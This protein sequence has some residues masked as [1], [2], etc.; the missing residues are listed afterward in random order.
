MNPLSLTSKLPQV[1]TTI[2]TV[3]SSLAREH[4]AINLSQGFPDIPCDDDL[5]RRVNFY[6]QKGLNQYAPMQGAMP[7]REQISSLVNELYGANYDPT[8]E[9][10]VT[11]GATE[12]LF[13]AIT[14]LIHEGDEVLIIEPAYDA[15]IPII[16]LSG[17]VPVSISL[18]FPDYKIDWEHVKKLINGRTRAIMLNSPHNPTGSVLSAD[19]LQ[20]LQKIIHSNNIFIISDEVWEHTVYDGE[21]HQSVARYPELASRSLVIS[22]FG[23]ALNATG[24]KVGYCLAPAA[25]TKEFRKVHQFVTFSTATPLQH[26]IADYLQYHR[27]RVTGLPAFYQQKRD[28]FLELMQGSR[29]QPIKSH[30]TYFQLMDYSAISDEGDVEFAKRLTRDHGVAS[31][32]VS[33]FYRFNT[34]NKVLRF[35]FAKEEETLAK[36]AEI[37]KGI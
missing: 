22:S 26:G 1:G 28:R 7:L 15:Y 11:S 10:T 21:L 24:W 20:Q 33:V 6:M 25:L 8:D 13:C 19:D 4:Q 9:I 23:K 17:G 2:F 34:D 27:E 14:A 31:I 35:C 29:F 3:M 32:P 12:A 37:L 30:G 5:T 18:D 36:A 16:E